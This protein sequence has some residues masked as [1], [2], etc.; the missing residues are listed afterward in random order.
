VPI[1]LDVAQ[2]LKIGTQL[3]S[4]EAG[5]RYWVD[6]PDGVGPKNVGFRITLTLKRLPS[7]VAL[8]DD[9][10]TERPLA[11]VISGKPMLGFGPVDDCPCSRQSD[12]LKSDPLPSSVTGSNG[13]SK[14]VA[15][16]RSRLAR[17]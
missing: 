4:L 5:V 13:E 16:P 14:L 15:V 10:P 12:R 2:I 11:A 3:L 6:T 7:E 9:A 8:L 1:N 17:E